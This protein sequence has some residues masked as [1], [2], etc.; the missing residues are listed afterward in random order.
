MLVWL[1]VQL[2]KSYLTNP[3]LLMW[4]V[5]YLLYVCV[6]QDQ[7]CLGKKFAKLVDVSVDE[8]LAF[9]VRRITF[10]NFISW[11]YMVH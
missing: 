4:L 3:P 11:L 2:I 8:L 5:F 6:F 1:Q 10:K 9:F 7:V